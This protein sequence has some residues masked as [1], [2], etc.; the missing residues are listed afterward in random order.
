MTHKPRETWKSRLGFIWAAVGSAVGFG[1]IWRFPYILGQNGGGNFLMLYILCL[2][3][4]GLPVL[5]A[6]IAIGRKVKLAPPSAFLKLGGSKKWQFFGGLSVLT[7]VLV[8]C[9]YAAVGGW[10]V[11]YFIK[12]V[13]GSILTYESQ[14]AAKE[15][16]THFSKSSLMTTFATLGF[17]GV[18][19]L[20]LVTGVQ[21]GIEKC[22]KIAMP[23]LFVVLLVLALFGISRPSGHEGLSFMFDVELSKISV[24]ALL[25][26][27]GQAFFS[28]SL[29]QGTMLTYGSY[30]TDRHNIPST[31]VPITFFGTVVS[32][33]AGMAIFP[34]VFSAGLEPAAGPALMFQTMPL[35]FASMPYL[36]Y[37]LGFLF[38][39][40]LLIA[41]VTSEISAMEPLIC[42][43]VDKKT[44]SRKKATALTS[45]VVFAVAGICALSTGALKGVTIFGGDLLSALVYLCINLL[46]PIG[47]LASALLMGWKWGM[48]PAL[49]YLKLN[50]ERFFKVYPFV[51]PFLKVTI[52]YLAPISIAIIL[53][54]NLL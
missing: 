39:L 10:V 28:L 45:L 43:L 6:E 51:A 49:E 16:F 12:A 38:F 1:S 29:G 3:L 50:N 23:F 2:L 11:A 48:E 44:M 53:I 5:V 40:L 13:T 22:S 4:V 8:S 19:Y 41:G 24:A 46:I 20:V 36:G 26:A 30:L 17:V 34:M 52:K 35:I 42:Y 21:S 47:G 33:L 9:F 54:S 32:I 7:G 27:L 37:V 25:T 31:C 14:A 18:C 15:A